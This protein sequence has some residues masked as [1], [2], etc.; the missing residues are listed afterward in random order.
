[1]VGLGV[2][3]SLFLVWRNPNKA[4]FTP[5]AKIA[6]FVFS[7]LYLHRSLCFVPSVL[8][9]AAGCFRKRETVAAL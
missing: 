2:H 8:F 4:V 3:H 6:G 7:L 9:N 1:M 5:H